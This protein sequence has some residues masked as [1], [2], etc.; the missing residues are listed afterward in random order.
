MSKEKAVNKHPS[1]ITEHMKQLKRRER[2]A[3]E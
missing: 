1:L 2:L 3:T